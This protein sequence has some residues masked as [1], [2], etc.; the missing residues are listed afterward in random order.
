MEQGERLNE[1][2]EKAI[3]AAM[4]VHAALGPGLLESAYEACLEFELKR[5]GLNVE[6][7]KALPIVYRDVELDGGYRLDLLVEGSVIVEVKAVA[8]LAPIHEAQLLSYLRLSGCRV[9]L[10]VN[11]NVPRL[12]DGIT[13]LVHNF[14]DPQRL[15]ANSAVDAVSNE[16]TAE[17]HEERRAENPGNLELSC[18][19]G[20]GSIC[21]PL[22]ISVFSAVSAVS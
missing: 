2:T 5:R 15:S 10:L 4:D 19:S 20:A 11:F 18:G 6:R 13:R 12:K 14:P 8:E 7:Q 21:G 22:R 9:G 16:H 1:L 3:G 17:K